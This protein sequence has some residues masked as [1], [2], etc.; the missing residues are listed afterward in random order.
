MILVTGAA[1]YI[2]SHILFSLLEKGYNVLAFDN[3]ELGHIEFIDLIKNQSTKGKFID[4]IKGDLRNFEDIKSVFTKFPDIEAVIHLAAYSSV[5]KSFKNPQ[6]YYYNNIL[7]TLNLINSMVEN[8]VL[9]LI[10][11]SSAAIY[12]EA[13]YL[14]I[15]ENHPKNPINPYGYSKLIVENIL[16]YYDKAFNLKSVRLRY[17]NVVGASSKINIGEWHFPET[18]LIPNILKSIILNESYIKI[19]GTDYE[20]KDGTCIRDFI[21]IE[22]LANAHILALNYLQNNSETNY[23][24]LGAETDYSVKEVFELC[25]KITNSSIE[26]KNLPRRNGDS[27]ALIATNKK[28]KTILNWTPK[29]TLEESI[30]TAYKWEQI[31]LD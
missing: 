22:D 11:S 6:N 18:H 13:K 4:F 17:F 15:D 14:P 19:F 16:D 2:G 9:K 3:L 29:N 5:E 31:L 12:G 30:K 27:E 1:G 7:G 8:N 25:K 28:A 10:F 21:N 26:I 24:N 23:F 20:T